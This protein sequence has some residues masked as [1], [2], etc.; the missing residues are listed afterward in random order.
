L[1][2]LPTLAEA[3][4]PNAEVGSWFGVL[5]PAGTPDAIVGALTREIGKALAADDAKGRLDAMG[6]EPTY[7]APEEFA[8]LIRADT[9]KWARLVKATGAQAE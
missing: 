2:D 5:A 9:E 1:P 7:L 6:A 4:V 8:R 3:G